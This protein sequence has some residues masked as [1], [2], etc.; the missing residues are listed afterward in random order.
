[1][2]N[3]KEKKRITS[4]TVCDEIVSTNY[5]VRKYQAF[6]RLAKAI[7]NGEY[8]T[9][10]K[11]P[12]IVGDDIAVSGDIVNYFLFTRGEAFVIDYEENFDIFNLVADVG[13]KN[14]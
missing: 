13:T 9:R 10:E 2:I 1:M 8:E 7:E 4:T 12:F 11:N 3:E 6:A 14:Q 5:M